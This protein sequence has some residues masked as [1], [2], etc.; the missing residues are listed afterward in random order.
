MPHRLNRDLNVHG[1]YSL[2]AS[3][4]NFR[5]GD[6]R[7]A[8]DCK[9]AKESGGV[10]TGHLLAADPIAE[11]TGT[12]ESVDLV[13]DRLPATWEV[14]MVEHSAKPRKRF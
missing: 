6:A 11:F 7:L 5:T 12:V 13:S 1:P 3:K 4:L 8:Q 14:V 2:K 10:L 9:R